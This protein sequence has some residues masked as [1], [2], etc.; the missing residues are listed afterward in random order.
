MDSLIV[1]II[2]IPSDELKASHILDKSYT[3]ELCPQP[4][5]ELIFL[6]YCL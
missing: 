2:A 5:T 6:I 3:T 1:I 4:L